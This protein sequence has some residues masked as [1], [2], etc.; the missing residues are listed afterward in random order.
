MLAWSRDRCFFVEPFMDD[1]LPDDHDD[2]TD[3]GLIY[4]LI[5]AAA[6]W[7]ILGIIVWWGVM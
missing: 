3:G 1:P 7:L 4:G 5:V 6:I 2:Y